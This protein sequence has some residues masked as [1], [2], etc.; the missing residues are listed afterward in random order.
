VQ[1]YR[2]FTCTLNPPFPSLSPP[3][4]PQM[5]YLEVF[6]ICKSSSVEDCLGVRGAILKMA[7]PCMETYF[8]EMIQSTIMI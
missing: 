4:L 3:L 2:V 7:T 1:W 6:L 8:L 5:H